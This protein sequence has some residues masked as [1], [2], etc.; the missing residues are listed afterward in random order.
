MSATDLDQV[1]AVLLAPNPSPLTLEG[2]NTYLLG[3]PGGR[4]VVVVDPGPDLTTHRRNVDAAVAEHGG[5][6][7]AVLVTHHHRDHAAASGWAREWD[8][9]LYAHDPGVVPGDATALAD[10]D[11]LEAAG[12]GLEV[13]HTPG[14][15]ADHVCLRV[16]ET[17]AVLTG[18]QVLGRGTTTVAGRDGDMAAYMA[19][20][21]RLLRTAPT[22]LYPGHGPVVRD[23]AAVLQS[24][25]R[26]REERERQVAAAL[27][28]GDTTAGQVVARLY[29]DVDPALHP[30]AEQTV[31]AHL[32][33]LVTEG[34]ATAAG[35]RHRPTGEDVGRR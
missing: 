12:L 20:L 25:L 7:E 10:G 35:L 32:A 1:T 6:V 26:H 21:H 17:G 8:A 31:R 2:T 30:A 4:G 9:P 14:H 27:E 22:V 23:P 34:R 16:R 11:V 33:K 15:S 28:A 29:A 18:D 5:V 3:V 19:S 24:Y 13:L